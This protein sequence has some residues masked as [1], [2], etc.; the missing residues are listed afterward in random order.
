MHFMR[1][2]C[3]LDKTKNYQC[4]HSALSQYAYLNHNIKKKVS[5]APC[6]KSEKHKTTSFLAIL[7]LTFNC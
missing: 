7:I 2:L 4:V 5:G 3:N 1:D 6:T